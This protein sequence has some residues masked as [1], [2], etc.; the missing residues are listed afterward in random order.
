MEK[1]IMESFLEKTTRKIH[2]KKLRFHLLG[3][4]HLPVSERYMGCAFTQKIVKFSKMLLALGHEVYLYGA[5]GS[6]APCTKFIQTHT[7]KEIREQWGEGDN[8]FEIGY[9]WKS[10]QFKHDM[11]T[12]GGSELWEKFNSRVIKEINKIKKEDDFLVVTQGLYQKNIADEVDLFLTIEPGIGYRG[13]MSNLKSGKTVYRGFESTYIQNFTYGSQFPFQSINGANYDRIV[14]NYFDS[15]DFKVG[16]GNGDYFLFIGRIIYRK[17]ILTA[18]EASKALG[19]KLVIAG[20]LDDNEK[21][22]IYQPH[23]EFVGYVEPEERTKLMGGAIATYV[24]TDYLE[25]FAG[26]HVE[27][28]LCGTPV[29]TTNFGVFPDT[30]INGVNGFRCNTLNDFVVAGQLASK[31]D[32]YTVR[33]TAERFLMDNVQLDL[34]KWF[35]DLYYLYLSTVSEEKAWSYVGNLT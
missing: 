23:C 35:F 1:H 32:R 3:L 8:R 10:T 5:E 34:N 13:S 14:P 28:M 27:S 7:L 20:Q 24:P 22:N 26:T 15:K 33:Q 17:G 30:V 9:D 31:L 29:I 21:P 12:N 18:I 19:K 2:D 4:V 25:P 16:E 6:D 11:N